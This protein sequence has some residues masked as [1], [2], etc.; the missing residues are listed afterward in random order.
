MMK[1][2]SILILFILFLG[3]C[4]IN[5]EFVRSGYIVDN[6]SENI[7][8]KLLLSESTVP[9][10]KEIGLARIKIVENNL[11]KAA[12]EARKTAIGVGGNCIIYKQVV[13]TGGQDSGYTFE[14]IVG[15]LK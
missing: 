8:V 13:F 2:K 1:T 15:K 4:D 14:F 7:N 3:S 10:Y 6:H 9:A 11:E 12:H 5:K